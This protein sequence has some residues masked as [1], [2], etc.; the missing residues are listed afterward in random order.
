MKHVFLYIIGILV[1]FTAC[2]KDKGNYDYH[3]IP[4]PVITKLDTAY[5]AVV[6]DSFI[7][8]PKVVLASGNTKYQGLW[9]I[10]VPGQMG[11]QDYTGQELRIVFGLGASRYPAVY[12]VYDSITGM[13]YY[14]K[15]VINGTATFTRG[16]VVLSDDVTS[17]KISF[18]KEDGT[19]QADVYTNI[20]HDT[21]PGGALQ[22]TMM[23][24]VNYGNLITGYWATFKTGGVYIDPNNLGKI[25]T[26]AKNFYSDPGPLE[27]STF[28]PSSLGVPVGII[29]KQLYRGAT[30]TAPFAT[31]YGFMGIP[32]SG[33]YSLSPSIIASDPDNRGY[34]VGFEETKR[35][36]VRMDWGNYL[37]TN[38]IVK[39]SAFTPKNLKMDMLHLGRFSDNVCYAFCD[40]AGQIRELRFGVEFRTGSDPVFH[41]LEKRKPVIADKI[42]AA[43]LWAESP[44]GVFYFTQADKVYRY[45]PLNKDVKEMASSFGGQTITMLKL[46]ENGN[47]LLVGVRGSIFYL[48]VGTGHNGETTK[49]VD[50][51][52]GAP[53]DV[54][55]R[56]N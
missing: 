30:E 55:V 6:G 27:V 3:P 41:A 42:S 7:I 16:T 25:R 19:V 9:K 5:M 47:Q 37:D 17:S 33:T 39:D 11:T 51:I 38:Y 12:I 15:F 18:I 35:K 44:V 21:L 48:N 46:L 50:G 1:L 14:Y 28:I 53:K 34:F 32:L 54:I 23:K 31:Y 22:L 49:R 43:T 40:S 36:M 56:T 52:P 26:L 20:N 4:E 45:N 2:Y 29:N 10:S 8:S 13:K 24:N